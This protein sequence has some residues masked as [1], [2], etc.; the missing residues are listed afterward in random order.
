MA[1]MQTVSIRL[2]DDDFQWLLSTQEAAGKTPSEK[3]RALVLRVRQ[4][5]SGLTDPDVC[6]EWMRSL[7]QPMANTVTM[8]ERRHKEHSDI[9][10]AA[11]ETVPRIMSILVSAPSHDEEDGESDL[12]EIEAALAQQCFRLLTTLLRAAITTVP[13]V[14][15]KESIERY[16]PDIIEIT[17]IIVTRREKERKNG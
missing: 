10:S 9:M 4:Q 16:L 15:D 3:L 13:A 2:P 1:Q 7:I 8:W 5:E 17:D 11:L 14:Y 6:S 12:R